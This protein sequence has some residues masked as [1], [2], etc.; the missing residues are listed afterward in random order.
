M[1]IKFLGDMPMGT[2]P[3]DQPKRMPF[4]SDFEQRPLPA[5]YVILCS[6]QLS[7]VR[8]PRHIF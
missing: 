5:V 1:S 7:R 3:N 6:G 2:H 8:G 4:L